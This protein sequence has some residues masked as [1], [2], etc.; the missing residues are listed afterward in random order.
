MTLA[1]SATQIEQMRNKSPERGQ[2]AALR[3][4]LATLE[5]PGGGR[6]RTTSEAVAEFSPFSSDFQ[7]LHDLYADSVADAVAVNAFGLGLA[8]R[9]A[10]GRPI[11]WG[12]HDQMANEAL[13]LIH[14]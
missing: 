12:L 1:F 14:I 2:I 9:T 3:T 13:S 4:Q 10:A 11:V 6:V 5:G 7:G 8:L